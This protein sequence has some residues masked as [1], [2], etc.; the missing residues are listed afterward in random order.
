MDKRIHKKTGEE[1]QKYLQYRHRGS[2]VKSVKEYD[3]RKF[4]KGE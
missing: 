2:R 3:H 1:H 4:K